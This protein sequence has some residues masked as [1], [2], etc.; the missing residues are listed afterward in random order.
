MIKEEL[1]EAEPRTIHPD[2]KKR[3]R[4][5]RAPSPGKFWPRV[6]KRIWEKAQELFQEEHATGMGEDFNGITAT[7]QE[8][9]EGGYFHRAKI[10]VLRNLYYATKGMP[11]VEEREIMERYGLECL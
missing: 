6:R 8:L 5:R 4:K 9:W 3:A 7:R 1:R 10:I 11:S 2:S